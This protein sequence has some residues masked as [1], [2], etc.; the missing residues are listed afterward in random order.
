[1]NVMLVDSDNDNIKNFKTYI[2]RSFSECKI[3]GTFTDPNKDIIP[4]IQNYKP[5]LIIADI[6]FFGGVRFMRFMDI[7][8]NFPNMRL[9][10]YGTFND[11]EYM[12]RARD[13]GVIDY[14]F[15]PV[16]PTELARCLKLAL[17]Q[18]KKDD[19]IRQQVKQQEQRSKD[20]IS[21]YEG[22]FLRGLVEGH[23]INE[24][25]IL[26]GFSHF[27]IKL[28]QGY[29]VA[30]V[31]IDHF[32]QIALTLT[33]SEKHLLIFKIYQATIEGMSEREALIFMIN[34]HSVAIVMGGYSSIEEKVSFF[35]EIKQAIYE[36]TDTRISIGLGRTYDLIT[37]I[38]ISYKEAM[39]A[40]LYRN[41]IG[42][43]SVI[44]L[45]FVEPNNH[46]TYRYPS[47]RE[48]RLVYMAVVGDYPYCK[49]VL[50]E[51]FDSLAQS[52]YIPEGLISKIL[53]NIVLRISRHISEQN[54][55]VAMQVSKLFPTAEILA[56][57]NLEDGLTVFDKALRS[58]CAYI[59]NYTEENHQRL[60]RAAKQYIDRL[61]KEQFS[62]AKMAVT[63]G[64]TPEH[65]NRIF[66]ERE[67][68]SLYDYVM[69]VRMDAA[70]RLLSTTELPEEEICT[71]VGFEDVRY[72]QSIFKQY[73]RVTPSEYREG[74]NDNQEVKS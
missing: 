21:H 35:D 72:F 46:I 69:R 70:R 55:P 61:Y 22:F 62:T 45:E 71:E 10:V 18:F 58:F 14:M 30:I 68:I 40:I 64:T 13:F 56:V 43:N 39:T 67:R 26:D 7:H 15:R 1:M 41:R 54:I 31:H 2:R 23:I 11:T 3:V 59:R 32:R 9:V 38:N 47:D 50:T 52:G 49:Q 74:K 66:K 25:E 19:V 48:D 4:S 29:T 16:K 34:F 8:S 65:L 33:E 51:L 27:E 24:D 20:N 53:M 12:R 17:S 5:D 63:L 36:K 60:F 42:Y 6:K 37:E 44:P 28:P 73:E 57:K